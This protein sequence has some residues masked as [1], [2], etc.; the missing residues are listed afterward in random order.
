MLYQI[1]ETGTDKSD[2]ND[3]I[4]CIDL[5]SNCAVSILCRNNLTLATV[6]SNDL[7]NEIYNTPLY[8][9]HNDSILLHQGVH[10]VHCLCKVDRDSVTS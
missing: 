9:E 1:M 6:N 5:V 4:K 10:D 3:S 7:Y 2:H 8:L